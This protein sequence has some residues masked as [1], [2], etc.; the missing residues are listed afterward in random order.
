MNAD[1]DVTEFRGYFASLRSKKA[2]FL[3]NGAQEGKFWLRGGG[4]DV[5][6]F[7]L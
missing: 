5:P 4:W 2:A 1:H 6:D 7:G 3:V